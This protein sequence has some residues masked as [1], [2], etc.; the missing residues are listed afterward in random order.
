LL[1]FLASLLL[2]REVHFVISA[3]GRRRVMLR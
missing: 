2:R 1:S 3:V